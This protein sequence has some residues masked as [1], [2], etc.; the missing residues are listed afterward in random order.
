MN[1]NYI[2]VNNKVLKIILKDFLLCIGKILP[3]LLKL[4]YLNRKDFL[5]HIIKT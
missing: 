5:S 4:K 3:S 2:I 1:V